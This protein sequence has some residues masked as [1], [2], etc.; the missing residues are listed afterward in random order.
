[1]GFWGYWKYTI[2]FP[3][4]VV[5]WMFALSLFFKLYISV[6]YTLFC[7]ISHNFKNDNKLPNLVE[8]F[9][10]LEI[11]NAL[12]FVAKDLDKPCPFFDTGIFP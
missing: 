4:V 12:L 11:F 9:F 3:S 7:F 10:H 1:M 6:S 2:S 8:F 5:L